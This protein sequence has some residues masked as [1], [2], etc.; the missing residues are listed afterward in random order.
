M[1][2]E[3][4]D[5][6][7]EERGEITRI[8]ARAAGGDRAAY[9]RLFPLIYDEL[10]S[11]AA[12]AMRGERGEHTLQATALV[13][14]AY[15]RLVDRTRLGAEG[16]SHFFAQAA[17]AM[18]RILVD[19]ARRK[20]SAKRGGGW[21]RVPIEDPIEQAEPAPDLDLL[22]LDEAL[23]LLAAEHPDKV[24]VVEMRFFAGM[25]NEEIASA[26]GLSTR[27]VE[28]HWRFARA[29]LYRQMGGDAPPPGPSQAVV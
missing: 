17:L 18:R 25:T 1:P 14:E 16:R 27:T 4:P 26:L 3:S 5:R 24:G 13:H 6:P 8:L 21:Q 29:W 19:H 28:R 22:A 7:S 15:I 9:D 11:L 12:R 2:D 23:T 20:R 10:R